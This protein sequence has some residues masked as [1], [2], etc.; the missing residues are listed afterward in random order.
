MRCTRRE[1]RRWT[2]LEV[3]RVGGRAEEICRVVEAGVVVEIDG[4]TLNSW[5]SFYTWAH[6]RYHMLEDGYDSWI[7]DDRVLTASR[8]KHCEPRPRHLFALADT[9]LRRSNCKSVATAPSASKWAFI[10]MSAARWCRVDWRHGLDVTHRALAVA[11]GTST[12]CCCVPRCWA[13]W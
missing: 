7:G 12:T 9:P 8:A 5:G 4:T 1:R 10:A 13:R 2:P 3:E 6:G 11:T